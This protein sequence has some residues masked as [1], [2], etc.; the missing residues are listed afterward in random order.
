MPQAVKA[1]LIAGAVLAGSAALGSDVVQVRVYSNNYSV[2]TGSAVDP[3]VKN[4]DT[5][6]WVWESGLHDV[7]SVDGIPEVFQSELTSD[8]GYTF[9]HTFTNVGA[10]HYYCSIH[11]FDRGN[12]TAGGM[13]GIITVVDALPQAAPVPGTAGEVNT[14]SVSGVTP[15][16]R[17]AFAYGFTS[18]Q[19]L[20]PVCTGLV[21]NL[22]NPVLMGVTVANGSGVASLNMFVPGQGSGVT[23]RIQAFDIDDCIPSEVV[24]ETF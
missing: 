2:T 12:G 7:V 1:I 11:G 8:V 22:T 9:D 4:G 15:G 24:T 20:V 21:A 18:G 14:F 10:W 23:A 5:I 19:T 17:V 3:I 16:N 6:R 13:A